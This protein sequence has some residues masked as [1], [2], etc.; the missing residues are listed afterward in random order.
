MGKLLLG[1]LYPFDSSSE[2]LVIFSWIP[3]MECWKS[4]IVLCVASHCSSYDVYHIKKLSNNAEV[5]KLQ[6]FA[7]FLILVVAFSFILLFVVLPYFKP[8][9]IL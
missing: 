5:V 7:F 6:Y 4:S 3:N 2:W 8:N 9:L 1:V